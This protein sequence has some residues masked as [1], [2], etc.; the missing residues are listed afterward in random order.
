VCLVARDE[1]NAPRWAPVLVTGD[2]KSLRL[3]AGTDDG[4]AIFP[5]GARYQPQITTRP[6]VQGS[7]FEGIPQ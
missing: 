4:L 7:L 2:G 5:F 6:A 3:A 1:L